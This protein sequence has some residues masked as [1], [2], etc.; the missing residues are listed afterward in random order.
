ML[1]NKWWIREHSTV[2]C[3]SGVM[4]DLSKASALNI[5]N[6]GGVFVVLLCGL[7]VAVLV[8]LMEWLLCFGKKD[9]QTGHPGRTAGCSTLVDS[10]RDLYRNSAEGTTEDNFGSCE[11]CSAVRGESIR[12]I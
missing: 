12:Y 6:I 2:G 8:A 1:Y 5:V 3:P 10:C 9:V 4:E 7:A 11:S